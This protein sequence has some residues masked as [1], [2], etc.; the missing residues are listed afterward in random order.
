MEL[1]QKLFKKYGAEFVYAQDKKRIKKIE[2]FRSGEI[3]VLI[4]TTILERGVTLS[5]ID[6]IVVDAD[7]VSYNV[8][9]LVQ[10]AGRVNRKIDDQNGQVIFCYESRSK[11]MEGAL[12]QIKMMNDL[13]NENI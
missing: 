4:T 7:R 1:K 12:K 9:T 5:N 6:V 3:N 11:A 8:A 2:Q 13:A 10:I